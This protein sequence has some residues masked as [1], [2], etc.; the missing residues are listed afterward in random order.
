MYGYIYTH[1][2]RARTQNDN[3]RDGSLL[4]TTMGRKK[5]KTEK[6]KGRIPLEVYVFID[7]LE[8]LLEI[9]S[10][11]PQTE[12]SH[13]DITNGKNSNSTNSHN[14]NN[15]MIQEAPMNGQVPFM[16]LPAMDL[17]EGGLENVDSSTLRQAIDPIWKSLEGLDAVAMLDLK[18]TEQGARVADGYVVC[19]ALRVMNHVLCTHIALSLSPIKTRSVFVKSIHEEVTPVRRAKKGSSIVRYVHVSEIPEK[20]SVGIFIFPP[21]ARIPLHDHPHMCVLSRV[22]YGDLKRL[23]L[24]LVREQ[25]PQ[26]DDS[27][28]FP[29]WSSSKRKLPNGTRRAYLNGVDHLQAPQVTALYPFEGQLHEFQAGPH[30]A[31]VLD[32]LLPPYDEDHDRDC[33]FYTIQQNDT[34]E[35]SCW[36]VPTNQPEDFHCLS[37]RYNELGGDFYDTD[38]APET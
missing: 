25:P 38:D 22:L 20:Y 28:W 3:D 30:G 9:R 16:G 17:I 27:S 10:S 8:R 32:V 13:F 6:K 31:A 33:T 21:N 12:G 1:G 7:T 4:T 23:S 26:Q 35:R 18:Q 36:I 11:S 15:N 29:R 37:G 14:N 24:D 2:T 19:S 5:A 34:D